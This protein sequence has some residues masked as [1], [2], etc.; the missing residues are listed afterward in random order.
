MELPEFL[1]PPP[2]KEAVELALDALIFDPVEADEAARTEAKDTETPPLTAYLLL[3]ASQS[4]DIPICADA[5]SEPARC[6]FDG[7]A[8]EELSE[9]GPWL[10]ELRRYGDAWDWFVED[11]YGQNWGLALHSRLPLMRLKTQLKKFIKIKDEDGD[12]YFFKFYRPQH[13]NTYL[14]IFDDEQRTSFMRGI[15]AI[16]AETEAKPEH[17]LRYGVGPDGRLETQ[18]LDLIETGIPLRILPPSEE[19]VD[20]I[21]AQAAAEPAG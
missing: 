6:L 13:L 1:A 14:P 3:D 11:G 7:A 5:F 20:K 12:T 21:L 10:I 9:V 15:D 8:F 16:F 18:T 2:E 17:L 4:A 19:D